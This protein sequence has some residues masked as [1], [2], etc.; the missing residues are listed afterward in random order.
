VR[1]PLEPAGCLR[2]GASRARYP[3]AIYHYRTVHADPTLDMDVQNSLSRFKKKVKRLGSKQK[4]GRTGANIDGESANPTNPPPRPGHDAV[5][6]SGGG[7]T[8]EVGGQQASSTDHPPQPDDPELVP[9]NRGENNQGGGGADTNG[10]KISLMYL[11]PHSDIEPEV[12]AGSEPCR[13]GNR[14]D[15]EEDEQFYSRSSTP[16][17]PHS[18]ESNGML[19]WLFRLL[20]SSHSQAT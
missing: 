19:A 15:G 12:G 11:P 1:T 7:N 17:V 16:S 13:D 4:L 5:L 10:R 6:D 20:P 9:A 2:K 3:T 14:A 18:Q 8:A